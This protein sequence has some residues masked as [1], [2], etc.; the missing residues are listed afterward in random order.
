MWTEADDERVREFCKT[1]DV[2][3]LTQCPKCGM[4]SG[5]SSE[6]MLAQFCTHKYCP[7]REWRHAKEAAERPPVET[8][9]RV[10]DNDKGEVTVTFN[11]RE[12]RGWSYKDD[13]ERRTKMLAAR[14]YVEGW[15]DARADTLD[16][17]AR[18]NAK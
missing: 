15:C 17:R 2:G 8:Q 9:P 10:V 5:G 7:F 4:G 1:T 11:G 16:F 13:T 14:E 12:L 3:K 6:M 18:R